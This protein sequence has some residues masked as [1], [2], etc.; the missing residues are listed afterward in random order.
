[1][2]IWITTDTHFNHKKMYEQWKIRPADFESKIFKGFLSIPESDLLIHLGDICIGKDEEMHQ[3]Y[4]VPLKCKKWLI[5]GNHDNKS[6]NWYLEH[7]WDF[8]G[9][10]LIDK[11]FGLKLL[12]SHIPT[13]LN[14]QDFNVHGHLHDR[15]HRP[16]EEMN[17]SKHLLR[18]LELQGYA[19]ITLE[20]FLFNIHKIKKV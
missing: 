12:F 20:H 18:S 17:D 2:N 1:M 6:N 8:V 16:D 14:G 19:P 10:H 3:K 5:R 11:Y 13:P 4:I 7:G 15:T 9:Y